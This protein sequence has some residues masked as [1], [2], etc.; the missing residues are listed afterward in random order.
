MPFTMLITIQKNIWDSDTA[1]VGTVL[2]IAPTLSQ[3]NK[4]STNK[5]KAF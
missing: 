2:S 1:T 3:I 4:K 5:I